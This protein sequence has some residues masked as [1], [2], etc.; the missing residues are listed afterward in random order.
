MANARA[1]QVKARAILRQLGHAEGDVER[2]FAD[3]HLEVRGSSQWVSVY[4]FGRI[5]FFALAGT[6]LLYHPGPWEHYLERVFQRT[7][8]R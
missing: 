5:V 4:S 1:V 8:G 7:R 2:E 3:W 6:P